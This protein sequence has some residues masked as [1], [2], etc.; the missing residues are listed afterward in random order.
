MNKEKI[1]QAGKIASLVR[2][3]IKPQ[4][5]KGTPLLEIAEKI[6]DKIIELGGMPAFPT[7][8]CTDN[9]TAHKTPTYNDEEIAHG[10]I[11]VDF[12]V[13]IDGNIA[14]TA[15][16]LDLEDN[17][18]NKKLISASEDALDNAIKTAK[19]NI[20]VNIIGKAIEETITKKGFSP[21][22]NLA[23]HKIEDYELHAGISIPNVN[24]NKNIELEN[25]LYAIE[26]FATNGSGK[27]HDGKPSEIYM[28]IDSKNVR[29]PIAR[30]MLD[31]ILEEYQTLPFCSRWLVKEFG[32]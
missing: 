4:I 2:D 28:V 17:D 13:H 24:D 22:R 9:M 7:S 26:P 15:F 25:G 11:K 6:E 27:V 20:P 32:T 31:F 30:Q 3:Y 12:G 10:L 8:L 29:S 21:V 16:S 5:K 14:D 23:G 18:E 1:L 19:E